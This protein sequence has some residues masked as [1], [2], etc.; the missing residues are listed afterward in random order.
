MLAPGITKSVHATEPDTEGSI[1]ARRQVLFE[2]KQTKK[3]VFLWNET[4]SRREK[5]LRLFE[6]QRGKEEIFHM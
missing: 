1:N 4:R 5:A 6:F 3:P 2:K